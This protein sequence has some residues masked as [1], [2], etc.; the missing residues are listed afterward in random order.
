MELTSQKIW[1]VSLL[2]SLKLKYIPNFLF[3][4]I[5]C[6]IHRQYSPETLVDFVFTKFLKIYQLTVSK[7]Q[8]SLLY[9][10]SH[11]STPIDE[12]RK[13]HDSNISILTEP[14]WVIQ[15]NN[16][17]YCFRYLEFRVHYLCQAIN[18]GKSL[19]WKSKWV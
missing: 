1:Y 4:S 9:V 17:Q 13:P 7:I 19:P 6:G 12:L 16:S 10:C 14:V 5:S 3:R 2:N 8:D 15:F 18:R 11:N